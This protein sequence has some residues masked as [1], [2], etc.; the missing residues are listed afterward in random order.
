MAFVQIYVS[1]KSC[2]HYFDVTF[3]TTECV[4]SDQSRTTLELLECDLSLTV[5]MRESC[6]FPS[7]HGARKENA[8]IYGLLNRNDLNWAKT[9][10]F[11]LEK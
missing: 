10:Y 7:M 6:Y 3:D 8:I 4:K 9:S 5:L 11:F 1:F 2:L